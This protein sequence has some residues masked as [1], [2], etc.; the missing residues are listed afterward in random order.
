M[1]NIFGLIS[2]KN[3]LKKQ[4]IDFS[5]LFDKY[6]YDSMNI[7]LYQNEKENINFNSN[8]INK[9]KYNKQLQISNNNIITNKNKRHINK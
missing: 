7:N 2:K 4:I 8:I 1:N 5:A 6:F 9:N 3:M